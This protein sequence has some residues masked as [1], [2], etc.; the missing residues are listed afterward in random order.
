MLQESSLHVGKS[1]GDL[2][3]SKKS[4]STWELVVLVEDVSSTEYK[5]FAEFGEYLNRSVA[6]FKSNRKCVV[7][8]EGESAY[9]DKADWTNTGRLGRNF[10]GGLEKFV[11]KFQIAK[12]IKFLIT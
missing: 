1:V 8:I 11:R 3:G 5:W 9:E 2:Y 6:R 4:S 10:G 12:D 7:W